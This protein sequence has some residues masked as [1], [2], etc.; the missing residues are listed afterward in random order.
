VVWAAIII[1]LPCVKVSLCGEPIV[2]KCHNF[3]YVVQSLAQGLLTKLRQQALS[4]TVHQKIVLTA[5]R[6]G[7]I[8]QESVSKSLGALVLLLAALLQAGNSRLRGL[9]KAPIELLAKLK[10]VAKLVPTCP[11]L[12]CTSEL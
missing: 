2:T 10:P 8:P 12:G 11:Q 6:L 4:E 1:L 5:T 3:C 7:C 9:A